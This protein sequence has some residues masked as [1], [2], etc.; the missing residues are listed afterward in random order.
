MVYRPTEKQRA[1][2]RKY[3]RAYRKRRMAEDPEWREEILEY[4][5]QYTRD[6]Y[7]DPVRLERHRAEQR[8]RA[9]RRREREGQ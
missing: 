6:I 1:Y 2:H 3:Q 5:R 8:E 9:R 7:A 4:Q